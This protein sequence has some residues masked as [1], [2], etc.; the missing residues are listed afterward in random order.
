MISQNSNVEVII[1]KNEESFKN[2]LKKHNNN[3]IVIGMGLVQ[4]QTDEKFKIIFMNY[5]ESEL[6]RRFGKNI[7][8]HEKLSKYSWF[9]LRPAKILFKPYSTEQLIDFLKFIIILKKLHV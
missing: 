3:E 7:Y 4:S 9:N 6:K 8:F 5:K 1:V 2:Y